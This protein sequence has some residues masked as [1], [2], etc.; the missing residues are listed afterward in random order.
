[1]IAWKFIG[2]TCWQLY[3]V[4]TLKTHASNVIETLQKF[5]IELY[6]QVSP[7]QQN[8]EK[9]NSAGKSEETDLEREKD[10]L[11]EKEEAEVIVDNK[12]QEFTKKQK[13]D[14]DAKLEPHDQPAAPPS[15]SFV[16]QK[17]DDVTAEPKD[18]TVEPK[19]A[20]VEPNDVTVE[21]NDATVEPNEAQAKPSHQERYHNAHITNQAD[22]EV[23]EKLDAADGFLRQVRPQPELVND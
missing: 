12:E 11:H 2:N 6:K 16:N 7:Q 10:V 17:A 19:D 13:S 21:P 15:G 18:V 1:M 4:D 3:V 22:F 5:A 9:I 8:S 23:R 14:R 20:T